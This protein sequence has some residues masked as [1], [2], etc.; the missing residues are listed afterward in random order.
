[1]ETLT[2][3]PG[4]SPLTQSFY[5]APVLPVKRFLPCWTEFSRCS[6]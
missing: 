5:P 6:T 1:M 2:E 3:P 4:C